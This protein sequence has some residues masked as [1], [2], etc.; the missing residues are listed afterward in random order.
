MDERVFIFCVRLPIVHLL[1]GVPVLQGGALQLTSPAHSQQDDNNGQPHSNTWTQWRE[2]CLYCCESSGI[3]EDLSPIIT[4]LE[5]VKTNP[6]SLR[7]K[8]LKFW[9]HL[10]PIFNSKVRRYWNGTICMLVFHLRPQSCSIM[11]WSVVNVHNVKFTFQNTSQSC[12]P[13][14]RTNP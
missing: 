11:E 2:N 3:S 12:T 8:V 6:L 9:K 4:V 14:G 13:K 1:H 5:F 7:R 10:F